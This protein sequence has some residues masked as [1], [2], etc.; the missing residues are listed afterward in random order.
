M[1]LLL[2]RQGLGPLRLRLTECARPRQSFFKCDSSNVGLCISMI[3]FHLKP[4]NQLYS[5]PGTWASPNLEDERE[6]PPAEA[7]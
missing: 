6:S 5:F 4:L 2:G 1:A 7:Q 3:D